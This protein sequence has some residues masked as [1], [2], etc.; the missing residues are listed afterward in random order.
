MAIAEISMIV[1]II[2]RLKFYN[3]YSGL[4]R[5]IRPVDNYYWVLIPV[6]VYFV[7]LGIAYFMSCAF[8]HP[9][10]ERQK[11]ALKEFATDIIAISSPEPA[12]LPVLQVGGHYRWA[13]AET[14][15]GGRPMCRLCTQRAGWALRDMQMDVSCSWD[16]GRPGIGYSL[17]NR[18]IFYSILQVLYRN[19][20]QTAW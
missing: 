1:F 15:I 14:P 20:W 11:V 2:G 17:H 16:F 13:T 19:E 3:A 9:T 8:C 12:R 4:C 18:R 10:N 6:L 5:F 7:C